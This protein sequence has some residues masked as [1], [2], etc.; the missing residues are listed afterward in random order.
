[1]MKTKNTI[2]SNRLEPKIASN[3]AIETG[4]SQLVDVWVSNIQPNGSIN[5]VK[6]KKYGHLLTT[7]IG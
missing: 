6:I 7:T 5:K 3:C 4:G 1:M 2:D